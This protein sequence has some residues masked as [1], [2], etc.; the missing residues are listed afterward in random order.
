MTYFFA[1]C[2]NI[3]HYGYSSKEEAEIHRGDF[4]E[5]TTAE[6]E[7]IEMLWMRSR[8]YR[9][10]RRH[11]DSLKVKQRN[12][13]ASSMDGVPYRELFTQFGF[14]SED[15]FKNEVFR[16]R[17]KLYQQIL[18]DPEFV[19]N[20]FFDNPAGGGTDYNYVNLSPGSTDISVNPLFVDKDGVGNYVLVG[21]SEDF[22]KQ[23]EESSGE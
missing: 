18:D 13:L 3:L 5:L 8:E 20:D 7:E 14:K 23:I 9:L 16:I 22:D 12:I 19:N 4:A 15:A 2:R 1:V 10:Y 17:K 6:E 21:T 11:F